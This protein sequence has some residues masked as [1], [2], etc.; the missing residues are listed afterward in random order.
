MALQTPGPDPSKVPV[1]DMLGVT[2][3]LLSA[4]F[5]GKEFI[6][7]GYYVNN[8]YR[9]E[10]L[11]QNPPPVSETAPIDARLVER[12]IRDD[13]PR[14]TLFP[15]DWDH[16]EAPLEPPVQ[17]DDGADAGADDED[18]GATSEEGAVVEEL[19][20]EDDASSGADDDSG[21][22]DSDAPARGGPGGSSDPT[23]MN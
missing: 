8:H 1:K 6:R 17:E 5:H 4:L 11:N 21:L 18:D 7:I 13:K 20:D 23:A 10:E 2:V 14:I 3:V 19:S 22:S 15:I 12:T 9:D 16:P